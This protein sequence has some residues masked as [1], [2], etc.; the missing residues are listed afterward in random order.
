MPETAVTTAVSNLGLLLSYLKRRKPNIGIP[1]PFEPFLG[2]QVHYIVYCT[3]RKK[4][5]WP[6]LR[7]ASPRSQFMN[8]YCWLKGPGST[9]FCPRT[10]V[11]LL[12]HLASFVPTW[13]KFINGP[14]EPIS[15]KTDIRPQGRWDK[16]TRPVNKKPRLDYS[17]KSHF[18]GGMR[19]LILTWL[20][21][22]P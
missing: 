19:I 15:G 22:R 14:I 3:R 10:Q 7:L 18:V 2:T 16:V 13:Y 5:S 17:T 6:S 8:I 4:I 9:S 21:S 12:L 20:Q 1:V 11:G